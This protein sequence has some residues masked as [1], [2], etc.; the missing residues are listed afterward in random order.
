HRA[1]A[2]LHRWNLGRLGRQHLSS[3]GAS[4]VYGS[5][6]WDLCGRTSDCRVRH[7]R[8]WVFTDEHRNRHNR[9]RDDWNRVG[10]LV[11]VPIPPA[12]TSGYAPTPPARRETVSPPIGLT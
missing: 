5:T 7:C 10:N 4:L 3:E 6:R 1:T 9:R 2:R 8:R 12:R 11:L